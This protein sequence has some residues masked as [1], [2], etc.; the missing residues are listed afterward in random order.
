MGIELHNLKVQ[1]MEVADGTADGTVN[2][3]RW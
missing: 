2:M 1:V 3:Q